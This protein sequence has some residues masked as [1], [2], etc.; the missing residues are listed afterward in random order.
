MQ[1]QRLIR[2]APY[3]WSSRWNNKV[4]WHL[5]GAWERLCHRRVRHGSAREPWTNERPEPS[6]CSFRSRSV[7]PADNKD[8]TA[9]ILAMA[10]SR[11]DR[12]CPPHTPRVRP[13]SEPL[14][15]AIEVHLAER[16][17][18]ERAAIGLGQPAG[19]Q[20]FDHAVETLQVIGVHRDANH[21]VVRGLRIALVAHFLERLGWSRS[22]TSVKT[23]LQD[24]PNVLLNALRPGICSFAHRSTPPAHCFVWRH[25]LICRNE[26]LKR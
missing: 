4:F 23:V 7:P 15:H 12:G 6:G 16:I 18:N 10:R 5:P 2:H 22:A 26:V 14:G 8:A 25:R 13:P 9:R 24:S 17:S 20:R 1:L 21:F 3:W 11:I 19:F